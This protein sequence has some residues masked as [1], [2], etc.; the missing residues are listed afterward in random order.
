M[1]KDL[2]NKM[3]LVYVKSQLGQHDLVLNEFAYKT[4]KV[5]KNY[6]GN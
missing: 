2:L 3:P 6:Y 1:Y 4:E 5:E